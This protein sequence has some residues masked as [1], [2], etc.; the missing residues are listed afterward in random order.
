MHN[1]KHTDKESLEIQK[2]LQRFQKSTP[3]YE[4]TLS[5]AKLLDSSFTLEGDGWLIL[6][7]RSSIVDVF[8]P[9]SAP[10]PK[11]KLGDFVEISIEGEEGEEN[12]IITAKVG[13]IDIHYTNP[14]SYTYKLWD[15]NG[16]KYFAAESNIELSSEEKYVS[17]QWEFD[18]DDDDELSCE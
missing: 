1:T 17:Y 16:K 12:E 9:P 13:R 5:S 7:P 3:G 18:E 8:V 15:I 11:F 2:C 6:E 14:V 4:D 10:K